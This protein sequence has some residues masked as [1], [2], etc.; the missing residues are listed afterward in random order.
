MWNACDGRHTPAQIALELSLDG[1]IVERA[2]AELGDCGLLVENE[3]REGISRRAALT[4]I[5]GAF[6]RPCCAVGGGQAGGKL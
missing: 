2:L 5:S 3:Q 1:V 4:W 6:V